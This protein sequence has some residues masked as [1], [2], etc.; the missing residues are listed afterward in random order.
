MAGFVFERDLPHQ[1]A[2]VSGVLRA[3]SDVTVEP[4]AN[5]TVNPHMAFEGMSQELQKNLLA[6]KKEG[7][8]AQDFKTG[9]E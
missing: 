7:D 5:G 1:N 3:L 8:W 2:A 9:A 6:L 4:S